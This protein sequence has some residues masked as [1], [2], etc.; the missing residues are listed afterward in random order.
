MQVRRELVRRIR[1]AFEKRVKFEVRR[2]DAAEAQAQ[3]FGDFVEPV[4]EVGEPALWRRKFCD[5]YSRKNYLA[6]AARDEVF[7][8]AHYVAE[9]PASGQPARAGNYAVGAGVVAAVLNFE[10]HAVVERRVS[11]RGFG[12][13]GQGGIGKHKR[14]FGGRVSFY[15]LS[16][17]GFERVADN[18]FHIG[19]LGYFVRVGLRVAAAYGD[20][21]VRVGAG[22]NAYRLSRLSFGKHGQ[23]A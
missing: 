10:V 17:A 8:V 18:P 4:C 14:L 3:K 1:H 5:V 13:C 11:A 9:S 20:G 19:K 7:G 23:G 16:G 12:A 21:A 15:N 22:E 6:H 2:L